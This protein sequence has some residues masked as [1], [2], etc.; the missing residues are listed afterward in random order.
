MTI[1][2]IKKF[3]I[4][5]YGEYIWHKFRNTY[6]YAKERCTNANCKDYPRY[7][8]L[9]NF[10][11]TVD[12][13]SSC[14][15][16]FLDGASVYDPSKLTIDRID[17]KKPYEKGNIRFVPMLL[18]LRNKDCVKKVILSNIM[19]GETVT[20]PSFFSISRDI[21]GS[22][23]STSGVFGCFKKQQ[24]YKEVWNITTVDSV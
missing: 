6:R 2:D 9:W 15:Q 13:Y 23:F 14:F 4:D 10:T 11:D 16:P 22:R 8:G 3:V 7:K 20:F 5:K 18:N 12:F 21:N 24:R 17:S 19:T 1:T